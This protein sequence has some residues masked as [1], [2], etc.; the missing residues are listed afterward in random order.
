[1]KL[2]SDEFSY[3]DDIILNTYNRLVNND[4]STDV[5]IDDEVREAFNAEFEDSISDYVVDV[6][7]TKHRKRRRKN[8]T[9][10]NTDADEIDVTLFHPNN[11]RNNYNVTSII[12]YLK[13]NPDPIFKPLSVQEEIEIINEYLNTDLEHLKY[14]LFCH[15]I[16]LV[17]SIAGKYFTK[18]NEFD[19]MVSRGYE[20]LF[21]AINNFDFS[22]CLTT[23]H[24]K[25][26][27]FSTYATFWIRK[28]VVWEF[29]KDS[30]NI[31]QKNISLDKVAFDGQT[32]DENGST[33]LE[34]YISNRL[35]DVNYKVDTSLDQQIY[36][37]FANELIDNIH[38]YI[39]TNKHNEFEEH[40]Y[41]IFYRIFHSNDS[42]KDISSDM[43]LSVNYV[44]NRKSKI[45]NHIKSMLKTEYGISNIHDIF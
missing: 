7:E 25:R 3:D 37:N 28:Y 36:C 44:N 23:D 13:L 12:N 17:F 38:G 31:A 30:L 8:T 15:H 39:Q 43:N 10:Q 20:G 42:I 14:L 22:R 11:F 24:P 9:L 19:E 27:K 16:R 32:D 40:D 6:N 5:E 33:I 18:T 1:M 2:N 26:I 4:I 21:H 41:E 29:C 45:V 34:N 35:D